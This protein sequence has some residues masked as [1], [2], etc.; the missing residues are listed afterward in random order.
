MLD[1]VLAVVV[2]IDFVFGVLSVVF[3][4]ESSP[5]LES[6]VDVLIP[7]VGLCED[8]EEGTAVDVVLSPSSSVMTDVE[9]SV[10][11]LVLVTLAS[12]VTFCS[13]SVE[14]WLSLSN[15]ELAEVVDSVP[16]V[17]EDSGVMLVFW[18]LAGVVLFVVDGFVVDDLGLTVGESE[19]RDL[20]PLYLTAFI[21]C[22]LVEGIRCVVLLGLVVDVDFEVTVLDGR[23]VLAL[24]SVM[25]TVT[26]F[27]AL[28]VTFATDIVLT[29][30]FWV[31][32]V[33]GVDLSILATFFVTLRGVVFV[34][35]VVALGMVVCFLPVIFV[36]LEVVT[37]GEVEVF[38]IVVVVLAVV[39][40]TF[41][42]ALV[43]VL[44]EGLGDRSV[45][46]ADIFFPFGAKSPI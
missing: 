27:V 42:V 22:R 1:D 16:F 36:A 38:T 45:V 23:V 35:V 5:F 15:V 46:S 11:L 12:I 29:F 13:E 24:S 34:V 2:F 10:S 8:V 37:L 17:V 20:A 25:F 3:A 21:V 41:V 39:V 19:M 7:V 43:V 32:E 4:V 18:S 14:F 33:V 40:V 30:G 31:V 28:V 44:G 6:V 26:F 9:L